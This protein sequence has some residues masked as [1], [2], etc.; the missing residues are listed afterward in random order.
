MVSVDNYP[1]LA[2]GDAL[3]ESQSVILPLVLAGTVTKGDVVKFSAHVASELPTVVQAT[4]Y[5]TNSYGVALKSGVSGDTIP[6]LVKGPVKVTASGG[7]TG[8]VKIVAGATG[9]IETIG[10]QTFEKVIGMA[11]QTFLDTDTGLAF[12]DCL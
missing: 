5:A 7:I 8:G 11:I 6:V 4:Q 9:L 12:I 3:D 1:A 10:S 2:L